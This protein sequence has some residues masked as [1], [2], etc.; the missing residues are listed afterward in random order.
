MRHN[1]PVFGRVR[2]SRLWR[3][4]LW[5]GRAGLV[6]LL[7]AGVG[8]HVGVGFSTQQETASNLAFAQAETLAMMRSLK[9]RVADLEARWWLVVG[10]DDAPAAQAPL[11]PFPWGGNGPAAGALPISSRLR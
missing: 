10:H 11:P 8:F 9:D 3:R 5:W 7:W 6:A 1:Q 4:V 2:R